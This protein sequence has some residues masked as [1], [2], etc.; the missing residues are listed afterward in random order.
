MNMSPSFCT[1]YF[2]QTYNRHAIELVLVVAPSS[3]LDNP[4][5]ITISYNNTLEII[6]ENLLT[7]TTIQNIFICNARKMNRGFIFSIK[8]GI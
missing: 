8:D 5:S 3:T 1:E 4:P 7:N 6:E 2:S